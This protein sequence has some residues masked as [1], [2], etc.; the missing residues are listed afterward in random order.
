MTIENIA[1][2]LIILKGQSEA[3]KFKRDE[4]YNKL[5]NSQLDFFEH[6]GYKF[7]KTKETETR[8]MTKEKLWDALKKADLNDDLCSQIFSD[9]QNEK[10]RCSSLKIVEIN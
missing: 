9:S 1:D 8:N 5:T 10:P 4:M 7:S 3:Y 6:S 2:E